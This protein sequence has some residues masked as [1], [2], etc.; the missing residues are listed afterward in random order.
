MLSCFLFLD[1]FDVALS[2]LTGKN[3]EL[4][5]EPDTNSFGLENKLLKLLPSSPSLLAASWASAAARAACSLASSSFFNFLA[6]FNFMPLLLSFD[7]RPKESALISPGTSCLPGAVV[8]M[9]SQS[10]MSSPVSSAFAR[11]FR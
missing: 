2:D 4:D 6:S 10:M 7:S 3:S 5:T 8:A 9:L 11:A 1:D